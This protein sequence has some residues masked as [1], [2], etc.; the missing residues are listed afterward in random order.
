[1]CLHEQK[2]CPRCGKSFECKPGNITQCQCFGKAMSENLKL[3]LARRYS[4]CLCSNCLDYLQQEQHLFKEKF[5][6]DK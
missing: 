6:P 2:S 3:F 1:M 4:D 5:L